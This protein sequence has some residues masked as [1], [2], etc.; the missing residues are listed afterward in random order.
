MHGYKWPINC[1][2]TRTVEPRIAEGEGQQGAAVEKGG[3][4]EVLF[5][6]RDLP[7][8]FGAQLTA[9]G[10]ADDG[11]GRGGG[12]SIFSPPTSMPTSDTGAFACNP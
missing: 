7:K 2:R 6:L 3:G 11:V 12:I 5:V 8:H 9:G 1:T 4:E 10:M